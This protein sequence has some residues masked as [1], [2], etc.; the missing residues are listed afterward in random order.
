[1]DLGPLNLQVVIP[2]T[3]EVSQ[4]QHRMNQQVN[5]Q[6]DTGAVTMKEEADHKQQQVTA[7]DNPEDGKIEKDEERKQHGQSSGQGKKEETEK[8]EE[9]PMAVDTFRG[10]H[11]DIKM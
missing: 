8:E 11:I 5:I 9:A 6:Q 1:M 3:T 2:K 4:I 10:H 7:K